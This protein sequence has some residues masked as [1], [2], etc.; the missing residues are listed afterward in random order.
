MTRSGRRRECRPAGIA[1]WAVTAL[2]STA[3]CGNHDSVVT[4]TVTN[5]QL[6]AKVSAAVHRQGTAQIRF[7]VTQSVPSTQ[8]FSVTGVVN[9]TSPLSWAVHVDSDQLNADLVRSG[10]TT[11]LKGTD[12][13]TSARPWIIVEPGVT[14]STAQNFSSMIEDYFSS[15]DVLSL[16]G[17]GSTVTFVERADSSGSGNYRY[18]TQVTAAQWAD[19]APVE[20]R[21]RVRR[22]ASDHAVTAVDISVVLDAHGLP[23]DETLSALPN[24]T[25]LTVVRTFERWSGPVAVSPPSADQVSQTW[26]G[27]G[28]W[29]GN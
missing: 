20:G 29:V 14:P 13:G 22:W 6:L 15:V 19:A 8:V 16:L 24:P 9:Y 18:Q 4:R 25:L 11:Y 27:S 12:I 26:T 23:V 10:E 17:F 1:V 5:G 2:L 3:A 7:E 21:E 28:L